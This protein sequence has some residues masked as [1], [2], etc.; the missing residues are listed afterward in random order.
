MHTLPFFGGMAEWDE[1]MKA[2]KKINYSGDIT[3][4]AGNFLNVLPKDLYPEGTKMMAA[5]ARHITGLME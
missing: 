3:L 2:L 1:I 4:E 5:I